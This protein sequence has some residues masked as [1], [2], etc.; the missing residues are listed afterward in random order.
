MVSEVH[1]LGFSIP[2]EV[3]RDADRAHAQGQ[4]INFNYDRGVTK[5]NIS[6]IA[7]ENPF[8]ENLEPFRPQVRPFESLIAEELALKSDTVRIIALEGINLW[9]GDEDLGESY[10]TDPLGKDTNKILYM[11]WANVKGNV[12]NVYKAVESSYYPSLWDK[13]KEIAQTEETTD[14]LGNFDIK[15]LTPYQAAMLVSLVVR[16]NMTYD[17]AAVEEYID[18]VPL[19]ERQNILE[20]KKESNE[21]YQ[22]WL[23]ERNDNLDKMSAD[24]L[25][26]NG[27]GVCR[28]V[29]AVGAA[30]Y[31]AIKQRQ[32][33]LLLNGTYFAYYAPNTKYDLGTSVV[34]NH[35]YNLLVVTRPET[36]DK[37]ATMD[38]TVVDL[39]QVMNNSPKYNSESYDTTYERISSAIG[40]VKTVGNYFI[41]DSEKEAKTLVK[42]F[43]ERKDTVPWKKNELSDYVALMN[44]NSLHKDTVVRSIVE[45]IPAMKEDNDVRADYF[46]LFYEADATSN[47]SDEDGIRILDRD[48]FDAV[49]REF[50]KLD[51]SEPGDHIT[52]AAQHVIDESAA[53]LHMHIKPGEKHPSHIGLLTNLAMKVAMQKPELLNKKFLESINLIFMKEGSNL[54][55][56]SLDWELFEDFKEYLSTKLEQQKSISWDEQKDIKLITMLEI[57]HSD[58]LRSVWVGKAD[59]CS[60][61]VVRCLYDRVGE[62]QKLPLYI[63]LNSIAKVTAKDKLIN[64]APV[65]LYLGAVSE[66]ILKEDFTAK[67]HIT[68]K[69]IELIK[70][71]L[72]FFDGE[73]AHV[74]TLLRTSHLAIH[75][76]NL[77]LK[78]FIERKEIPSLKDRNIIDA[79]INTAGK[80]FGRIDIDME[81]VRQ[82]RELVSKE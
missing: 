14:I 21:K 23:K 11:E 16:K 80:T 48:Y 19:K 27:K 6:T 44:I 47:K 3:S 35:A 17:D 62:D 10:Q 59:D 32:D 7:K 67:D 45:R 43:L 82:Y 66:A 39:T 65:P 13:V 46:N 61:N 76:L 54:F 26:F 68:N 22:E 55:Y 2:P 56:Q 15:N 30:L 49:Y 38:I 64:S 72:S 75:A 34:N 73:E 63:Y 42:R 41:D 1:S 33:G 40:F 20:M 51:F 12:Y 53:V 79:A 69:A 78:V 31:E 37:K 8:V 28:H 52:T 25:L 18:W 5:E 4:T 9:L 70:Q 71:N 24:Y 58:T 57:I 50:Q 60:R 74:D 36:K 77:A 81:L 29:S